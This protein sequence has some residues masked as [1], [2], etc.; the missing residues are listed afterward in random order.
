M[1]PPGLSIAADINNLETQHDSAMAG[2]DSD[3]ASQ[4]DRPDGPYTD[5]CGSE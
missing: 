3:Q 2:K 5:P 4:V 1:L